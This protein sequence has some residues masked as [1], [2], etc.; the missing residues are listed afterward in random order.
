MPSR[1]AETRDPKNQSRN[2]GTRA[3]AA[4][5]G[6]SIVVP[7]LSPGVAVDVGGREH[8][9]VAEAREDGPQVR[10]LGQQDA[11]VAG[12]QDVERCSLR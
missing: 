12:A 2:R 11:R 9:G 5:R 3:T 10:A 8:G 1:Y 4:R 6:G 7:I